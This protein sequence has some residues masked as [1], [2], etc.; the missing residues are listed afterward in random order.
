MELNDIQRSTVDLEIL[1]PTTGEATGLVLTLRSLS[2]PEMRKMTEASLEKQ[3]A[4]A[5]R[6]KAY[7]VQQELREDVRLKAAC[8]TGIAWGDAKIDGEQPAYSPEVA[9][10]LL[11]R[12]FIFKQV[13]EQ[14]QADSDFFTG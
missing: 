6:G 7:T 4:S 3:R 1:H 14:L 10:K 12:D 5:R 8:V 11:Q 2:D 13:S 9:E